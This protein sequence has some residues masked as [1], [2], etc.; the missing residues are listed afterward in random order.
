MMLF[1]S[2][3][4]TSL[5][6][7]WGQWI[8]ALTP[9]SFDSLSFLL[10][11]MTLPYLPWRLDAASGKLRQKNSSKIERQGLCIDSLRQHW[12]TD[13]GKL[14]GSQYSAWTIFSRRWNHQNHKILKHYLVHSWPRHIWICCL[15]S[16]KDPVLPGICHIFT[17]G[18][19]P[20]HVSWL[21]GL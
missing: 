15:F 13:F 16:G 14:Q 2:W 20:L 9:V 8:I 6:F 7:D 11:C 5:A 18:F 17:P 3:T 19:L 10:L 12:D 1:F 21:S 4:F